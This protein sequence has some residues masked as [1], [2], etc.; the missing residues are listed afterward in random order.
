MAVS[1]G[2]PRW[3]NTEKNAL[4]KNAAPRARRSYQLK[5]IGSYFEIDRLNILSIFSLVASTAD[6][7]A[8]AAAN[9]WFAVLCAL[10]AAWLAADAVLFA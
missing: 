8:W 5:P 6:W 2:A 10:L 9:A 7:L 3:S 1:P 4:K